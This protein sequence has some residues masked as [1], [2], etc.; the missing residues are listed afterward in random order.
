MK[1]F[2][3]IQ[4]MIILLFIFQ[5]LVYIYAEKNLNWKFD[6]KQMVLGRPSQGMSVV[7]PKVE[8]DEA[9]PG[10]VLAS[11][12]V[13][14]R[15]EIPV[16]VPIVQVHPV[17]LNPSVVKTV[18]LNQ[19]PSGPY[20]NVIIHPQQ[21]QMVQSRPYI[22]SG[23]LSPFPSINICNYSVKCSSSSFQST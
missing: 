12:G 16:P 15:P 9:G 6:K 2:G 23:S 10:Q 1:C 4:H 22:P 8:A 19:V 13:F 14:S 17:Q 7:S 18:S 3:R 11:P 20:E 21:N 5:S